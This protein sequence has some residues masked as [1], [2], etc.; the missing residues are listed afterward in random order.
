MH[1]TYHVGDAYQLPFKAGSFDLVLS[2][3]MFSHLLDPLSAVEEVLRL[4]R[5]GGWLIIA[6]LSRGRG[7]TKLVSRSD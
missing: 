6:C 4:L 5:S 1:R 3:W 7:F 2:T